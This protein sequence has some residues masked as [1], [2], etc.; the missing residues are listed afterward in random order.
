[1]I[2]VDSCGWLEWFTDGALAD[3]YKQYLADSDNILVPA[4]VFYEVYKVLKREAGEEKAL[5]AAGYMRSSRLIPFD[6]T[7]ALAAADIA[8]QKNLAMTDAIIVAVSKAH[9]CRIVSSDA[10]LKNLDNVDYIQKT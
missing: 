2:I 1:M 8:L 3:N 10:D 7:L 6:D 4:I 5:L 9:N